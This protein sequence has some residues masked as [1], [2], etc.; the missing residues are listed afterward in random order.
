MVRRSSAVL[1][2]LL[3]AG[4]CATPS[5]FAPRFDA[6]VLGGSGGIDEGDLTSV[7]L[8]RAGSGEFI[9]LDAGTL[10]AGLRRAAAS[11]AISSASEVLA[12]HL[13]GVFLSHPHLDHVSGLLLASPEAPKLTVYGLAPTL[14][15]LLAHVFTSPL[16]ANFSDEGPAALGRYHLERMAPRAAVVVSPAGLQVEAWELSHAGGLSTAFLVSASDDAVLFLG[17]TGPDVV[18]RSERLRAVWVRVAPLLRAG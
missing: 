16:W 7:L 13:H 17:D 2:V 6:V 14:D 10:V 3:A 9:A 8:S 1:L 4:G 15:A 12:R 5:S 11:R 18:E